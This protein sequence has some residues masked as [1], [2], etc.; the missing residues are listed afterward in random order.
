MNKK[1]FTLV[2]LLA[3]VVIMALIMAFAFP[4]ISGMIKGSNEKKY[5]AY[6][7]SM[8][9]YAKA[10]YDGTSE[11]IGLSSLKSKGLSGIDD[12]CIGYVDGNNKYRAYIKC[13]DDYQTSGFNVNNVS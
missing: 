4:A 13:G 1:G 7:R 11:I 10:Y 12:K 9:E 3:V 2:E 8:M 6:E 5:E